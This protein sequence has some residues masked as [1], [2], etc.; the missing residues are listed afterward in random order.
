[1]LYEVERKVQ[2]IE[3]KKSRKWLSTEEAAEYL[4][5]KTRTLQNYQDKWRLQYKAI[6][7]KNVL[8]NLES[9]EKFLTKKGTY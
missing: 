8:Y 1:M 6:T 4:S 3:N 2:Q 9:I 5:I 7:K